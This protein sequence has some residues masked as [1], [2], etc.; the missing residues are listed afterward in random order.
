MLV[1]VALALMRVIENNLIGVTS[2][3]NLLFS[4]LL[5]FKIDV[6]T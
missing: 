6:R 3:Y 1:G 4:L 5:V 2:A